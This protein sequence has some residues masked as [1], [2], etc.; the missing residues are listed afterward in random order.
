MWPGVHTGGRPWEERRR[1]GVGDRAVGTTALT[2]G[3][4]EKRW[5]ARREGGTNSCRFL[6]ARH[7]QAGDQVLLYAFRFNVRNLKR[8]V[9]ALL[10]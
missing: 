4:G 8:N 3:R 1:G 7:G 2:P 6:R 9:F 5:L 10:P